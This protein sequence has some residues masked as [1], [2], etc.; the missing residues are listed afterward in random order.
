MTAKHTFHIRR[1]VVI[2]RTMRNH[3][4]REIILA[5]K[6]LGIEAADRTL[7]DDRAALRKEG[8]LPNGGE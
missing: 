7:R 2:N 6:A 1:R 5:L 4:N 3:S 8:L